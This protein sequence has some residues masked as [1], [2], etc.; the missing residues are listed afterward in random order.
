MDQEQANRFMLK[1]TSPEFR[2]TCKD[3]LI[4]IL[5]HAE[6]EGYL[7]MIIAAYI[8]DVFEIGE[9]DLLTEIIKDGFCPKCGEKKVMVTVK[10][11]KSSYHFCKECGW[12]DKP[13]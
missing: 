12:N 11:D 3:T 1:Q 4:K 7:V 8:K 9:K 5:A 13:K 2:A 6:A 10:K